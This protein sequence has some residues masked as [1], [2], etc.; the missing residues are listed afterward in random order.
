MQTTKQRRGGRL[1]E[2]G[3]QAL[4]VLV[5]QDSRGRGSSGGAQVDWSDLSPQNGTSIGTPDG[6]TQQL[7]LL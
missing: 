6:G 1:G 7:Q 4:V 2:R 3:Q 5:Y